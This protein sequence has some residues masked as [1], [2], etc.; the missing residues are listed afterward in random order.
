VGEI[1]MSFPPKFTMRIAKKA[2]LSEEEAGIMTIVVHPAYVISKGSSAELLKDKRTSRSSWTGALGSGGRD[3][4]LL[5]QNVERPTG[6]TQR[7]R[8]SK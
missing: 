7:K 4:K 6:A 8:S 3:G 1:V 2:H 5:E